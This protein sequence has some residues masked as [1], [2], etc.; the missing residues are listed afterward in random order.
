M[1]AYLNF[2]IKLFLSTANTVT[3]FHTQNFIHRATAVQFERKQIHKK[4]N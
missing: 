4:L 2:V 3:L 1:I